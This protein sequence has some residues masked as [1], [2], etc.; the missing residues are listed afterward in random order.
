MSSGLILYTTSGCH[1]CEQ[2]EQLLRSFSSMPQ[3]QYTAVDI[4]DDPELFAK[5]GI[6]IPVIKD[7]A[8]GT[9]IGWPFDRNALSA[10]IEAAG[11][12]IK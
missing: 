10:F 4:A 6:T 2:A 7:R 11:Q 9:E 5:Y 8:T 1:L 12:S 3:A